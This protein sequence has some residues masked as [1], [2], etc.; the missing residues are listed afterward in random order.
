MG[1]F[2]VAYSRH[3]NKAWSYF[4][5]I[6][7]KEYANSFYNQ[8][9]YWHL[10]PDKQ[11]LTIGYSPNENSY[12]GSVYNLRIQYGNTC[13]LDDFTCVRSKIGNLPTPK[14]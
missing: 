1:F 14:P 2:Y 8:R 11:L 4:K 10:R 9:D 12:N 5:E 6:G 3:N 13:Q 7:G